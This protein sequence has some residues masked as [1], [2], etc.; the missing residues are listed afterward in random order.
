MGQFDSVMN[1]PQSR[2]TFLRSMAVL[3]GMGVLAACRKDVQS[4]GTGAST[5]ASAIPRI[6]DEDG[7]LLQVA[8]DLVAVLARH[9]WAHLGVGLQ[10][11]ADLHE[12]ETLLDRVHDR[13]GDV[14]HRHDD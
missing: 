1:N 3:G 5:A 2:R 10:S 9:E 13:V 12:R 6:E 7:N 4:S 8:G 14:A 11:V